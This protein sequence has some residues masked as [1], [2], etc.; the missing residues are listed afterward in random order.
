MIELLEPFSR[1]MAGD[2]LSVFPNWRSHF[3][4]VASAGENFFNVQVPALA[5]SK[6]GPLEVSSLYNGEV[7]VF[8]ATTHR[9]FFSVL[10]NADEAGGAV[11]FIRKILDEQLA[12]VSYICTGDSTIRDGVF[13]SSAVP[14]DKI[15]RANYE[16]YYTTSMRVRSWKGTYDVDFAAPYVRD[17]PA[18]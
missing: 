13:S 9:H 16:Y 5:A 6:G 7:T 2:L 11:D 18:G 10:G 4:I 1:Q 14:V 3:Y 15:P 8:Y 17:K 12:V